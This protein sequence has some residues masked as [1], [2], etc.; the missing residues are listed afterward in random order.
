MA[1]NTSEN[2]AA[3]EITL[4]QVLISRGLVEPPLTADAALATICQARGET[5]EQ[6]LKAFMRDSGI[7]DTFGPLLHQ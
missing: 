4:T 2:R 3:A 7:I 5:P 6:L 1:R